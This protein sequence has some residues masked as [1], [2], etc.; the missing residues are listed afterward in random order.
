MSQLVVATTA[1]TGASAG[2]LGGSMFTFSAFVMPALRRLPHPG[3]ITAMQAINEM[4][5]RSLLMLPM[6]GSALGSVVVG[7]QVL[8]TG[9]G[10]AL[11][12]AGAGLG[13][14][15]LVITAAANVPQN[16]ALDRLDPRSSAAAAQWAGFVTSWTR[17]NHLRTVSALG[18][19][20]LL[21]ASLRSPG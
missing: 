10:G 17:W 14:V 15:A 8:L 3:G 2:V 9:E 21:L 6:L 4:A 18:S 20:A 11:R 5:P 12:L 7:A 1:L 13:V 19:A 16:N